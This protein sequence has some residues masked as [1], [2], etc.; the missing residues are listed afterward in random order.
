[1]TLNGPFRFLPLLGQRGILGPLPRTLDKVVSIL[2]SI[3]SSAIS[4]I[5]FIVSATRKI[6]SSAFTRSEPGLVDSPPT[7]IISAPSYII[8]RACFTAGVVSLNFPPSEKLSGVTFKIPIINGCSLLGKITL[9]FC[10]SFGTLSVISNHIR[11]VISNPQG[12]KS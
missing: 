6:C 5:D 9:L 2:I 12:E 7:S 3:S 4:L 1:M 10:F 8:S 11:S